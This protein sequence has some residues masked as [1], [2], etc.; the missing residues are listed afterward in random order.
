MRGK[1]SSSKGGDEKIFQKEAKVRR[2]SSNHDILKRRGKNGREK[3]FPDAVRDEI[4]ERIRR[5]GGDVSAHLH[6]QQREKGVGRET[7]L[8]S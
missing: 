7:L 5:V 8:V 3:R 2:S 1:P 4:S 6:V